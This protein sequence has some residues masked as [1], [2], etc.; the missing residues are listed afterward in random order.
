[1]LYATPGYASYYEMMGLPDTQLSAQYYF[2][3]YNNIA[4]NSELR[5]AV[6]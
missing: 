5:F 6:P 3:W 1:M 4:M 2:P